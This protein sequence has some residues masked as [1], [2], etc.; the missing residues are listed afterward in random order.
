MNAS[1]T[2][3][4]QIEDERKRARQV[5]IS[6]GDDG[7]DM[8]SA[9]S[10]IESESEIRARISHLVR[11]S[12]PDELSKK[13][14]SKKIWE[15]TSSVSTLAMTLLLP[16]ESDEILERRKLV[17]DL[18]KLTLDPVNIDWLVAQFDMQMTDE[19]TSNADLKQYIEETRAYRTHGFLET[20]DAQTWEEDMEMTRVVLERF[21]TGIDWIRGARELSAGSIDWA[22]W[23]ADKFS[24]SSG[25]NFRLPWGLVWDDKLTKY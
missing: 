22:I 1:P 20:F 10:Y 17:T 5:F 16:V 15:L 3:W 12:I 11:N 25:W 18:L 4:E 21:G 8:S 13:S 24:F 23:S 7:I 9:S 6:V 2:P 14:P 19:H